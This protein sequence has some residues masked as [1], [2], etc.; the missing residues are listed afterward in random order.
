MQNKITQAFIL[1]AGLG[2]RLRPLTNSVPKVMLPIAPGKPLLEHTIE[3]LREQGIKDFIINVHYLPDAITSYFGDGTKWGVRVRYSDESKQL[4]ETAGALKKSETMLNDDFLFIYGDELHFF[5]FTS[6]IDFHMK[7]RASASIVLKSSD[8]P[9]AGEIAEFDP[10][11]KRIT[12]WHTRPHNITEY[13]HNLLV[14]AGLY[15]LSKKILNYVSVGIPTKLDGEVI[16]KALA[17]GEPLYAF[18]TD[19]PIL[20]IGTPEKYEQAKE[21]YSSHHGSHN[22]FHLRK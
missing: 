9:Q 5:N 10:A 2:T 13:K 16:P 3:L 15:V 14:N 6:L 4:L 19:Q 11:T 8:V 21:Y 17:A 22:M 20:D 1:G 18:P 7:N 12:Q